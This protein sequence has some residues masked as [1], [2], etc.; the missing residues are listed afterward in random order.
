[1]SGISKGILPVLCPFAI[2]RVMQYPPLGFAYFYNSTLLFDDFICRKLTILLVLEREY[3]QKKAH[4]YTC[5]WL[6]RT[7][8]RLFGKKGYRYNVRTFT[9]T[10]SPWSTR[11]RL[12]VSLSRDFTLASM[13]TAWNFNHSLPC[14]LCRR[15]IHSII[16]RSFAHCDESPR[17]L[18][19]RYVQRSFLLKLPLERRLLSLFAG[20]VTKKREGGWPD[21]SISH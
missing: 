3:G 10:Y 21:S 7:G 20:Q 17:L 15:T 4:P 8:W 6:G 11:K 14:F 1:M 13:N 18:G 5:S 9:E 19:S 16:M 12:T 2:T